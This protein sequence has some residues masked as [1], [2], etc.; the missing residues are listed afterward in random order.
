MRI[1][2]KKGWSSRMIRGFCQRELRSERCMTRAANFSG[3]LVSGEGYQHVLFQFVFVITRS[4]RNTY[5]LPLCGRVIRLFS[6]MHVQI[7]GSGAMIVVRPRLLYSIE[8]ISRTRTA[9]HSVLFADVYVLGFST[10][11]KGAHQLSY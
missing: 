11:L 3:V 5:I 2:E 8:R 9:S 10:C 4:T 7:T 6:F 1:A